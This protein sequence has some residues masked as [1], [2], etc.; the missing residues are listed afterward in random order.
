MAVLDKVFP[1]GNFC[2]AIGLYE[3]DRLSSGSLYLHR[4]FLVVLSSFTGSR[5]GGASASPLT[6]GVQ[7]LDIVS[8]NE[9]LGL[10]LS[11][12]NVWTRTTLE[13]ENHCSYLYRGVAFMWCSM[14]WRIPIIAKLS[15]KLKYYPLSLLRRRTP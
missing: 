13:R 8:L 15:C 2:C 4:G 6:S 9:S 1:V 5:V 10:V 12:H 3:R 11:N 7:N 14:A